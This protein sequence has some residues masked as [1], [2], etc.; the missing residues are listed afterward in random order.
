MAGWITRALREPLLLFLLLG[1]CLFALYQG[2]EPAGSGLAPDNE[3]IVITQPRLEILAENFSRVWQRS[4]SADELMGMVEAF[5]REEVYYR[6]AVAMGLDRDD[7]VVRRRMQQKMEFLA[8]ELSRQVAP[9]DTDLQAYLQKHPEKF[10]AEPKLSFKQIYF[11]PARHGASLKADARLILVE[12][13]QQ[14]DLTQTARWGDRLALLQSD[15]EAV[16]QHQVSRLFGEAFSS[17]LMGIPTAMWQGPIQSGYGLHLVY[18]QKRI[19]ATLPKLDTVREAV[20]REWLAGRQQEA[21]EQ[22]YQSLR[23]RY[24]VKID[25]VAPAAGKNSKLVASFEGTK[26]AH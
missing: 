24:R 5:T 1:G 4:P 18:V 12:L 15:Y 20:T 3:T 25:A 23:Q 19:D 2:L 16:T 21:K 14:N 22:L 7:T 9:S 10:R 8:E 26:V 11:D 13:S 6:E 17:H